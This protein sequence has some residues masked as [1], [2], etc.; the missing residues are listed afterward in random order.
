MS[1]RSSAMSYDVSHRI[2]LTMRLQPQSVRLTVLAKRWN[3]VRVSRVRVRFRI[4]CLGGMLNVW[5]KMPT[6]A[7]SL[8]G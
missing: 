8:D 5:P 6:C 1:I 2:P 3:G 7:V 4:L